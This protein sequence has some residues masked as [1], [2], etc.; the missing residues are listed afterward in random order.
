[1]TNWLSGDGLVGAVAA[2]SNCMLTHNSGN[3]IP[4]NAMPSSVTPR[5]I[6]VFGPAAASW[7]V[8]YDNTECYKL[9]PGRWG[10]GTT[11]C[12][13]TAEYVNVSRIQRALNNHGV[14]N[15]TETAACA[16]TAAFCSRFVSAAAGIRR[17]ALIPASTPFYA[18]GLSNILGNRGVVRWRFDQHNPWQTLVAR[19]L[20]SA[21]RR[22]M[23]AP[24]CLSDLDTAPQDGIFC[25]GVS[26]ISPGTGS[27][28]LELCCHPFACF[29]PLQ[30]PLFVSCYF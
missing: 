29:F 8:G 4:A 17:A 24:S 9:L 10:N 27:C 7:H 3:S 25:S 22:E 19:A 1:M 28:L 23:C 18:H 20:N 12:A 30:S 15:T 13:G 2:R 5:A 6:H 21:T 14:P 26:E 11:D 16:V